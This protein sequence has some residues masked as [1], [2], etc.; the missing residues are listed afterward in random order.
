M[1]DFGPSKKGLE[2]DII[3]TVGSFLNFQYIA[4]KGDRTEICRFI[5]PFPP[6]WG[7]S[8]VE[9]NKR[10]WD[11]VFLYKGM[12]IHRRGIVNDGRFLFSGSLSLK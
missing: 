11:F 10:D 12:Y 6:S 2:R 9:R 4:S 1:L 8:G 7:L 3:L 5:L